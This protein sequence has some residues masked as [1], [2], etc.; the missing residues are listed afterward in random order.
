[1]DISYAILK[2]VKESQLINK[3]DRILVGVSGGIDSV[4]LLD[5][6]ARLKEELGLSIHAAHVNY[7]LRGKESDRDEKF[8]RGLAKEYDIP[9]VIARNKATKPVC[10][11]A[12]NLPRVNLQNSAREL[13]YDFFLKTAKKI[14]AGKIAVAHHADDQ[15]ETVLLHLIRGSGLSGLVGMTHTSSPPLMG[16]DKGEGG[17]VLIRPLL[18]FTKNGLLAYAKER[19]LKFVQDR[20]NRTKKYHRN[21]IRHELLPL[22]RKY[23]PNVIE[24]VCKTAAILRD[25]N[26]ALDEIA[27]RAF[28]QSS[29]HVCHP[30]ESGNDKRIIHKVKFN[31]LRFIKHHIAIRRRILRLAY[32]KLTGGTADLLNDHIERMLQIIGSAKKEG[33]YSLP[34]GVKFIRKG[35]AII[36]SVGHLLKKIGDKCPTLSKNIG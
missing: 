2:G 13:R 24:R 9:C 4:V 10:R 27:A 21:V 32:A 7:G 22:L 14:K 12:G 1:M 30:R 17:I 11:Q 23:N 34:N 19:G 35:D 18:S 26:E 8:V 33:E 16:G 31:R 15:A 29:G 36:L 6:L 20:T 5:I 25:E 28:L 3:G